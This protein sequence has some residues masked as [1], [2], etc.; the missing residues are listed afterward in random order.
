MADL[1][2]MMANSPVAVTPTS[3]AM[4]LLV[5]IMALRVVRALQREPVTERP[6]LRG[7]ARPRPRPRGL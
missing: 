7:R 6:T 2:T 4:A 1:I 5:L 3:G